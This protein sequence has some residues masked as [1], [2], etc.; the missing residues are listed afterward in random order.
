MRQIEHWFN[1]DA[2]LILTW[3]SL[4]NYSK[5]PL[6]GNYLNL[7]GTPGQGLIINNLIIL[8]MKSKIFKSPEKISWFARITGA[9]PEILDKCSSA[10]RNAFGYAGMTLLFTALVSAAIIAF[11]VATYS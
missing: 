10:C 11:A 2:I 4:L 6:P 1:G 3:M 9:A 7:L 8:Q 5:K